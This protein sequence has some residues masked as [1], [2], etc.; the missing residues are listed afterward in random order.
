MTVQGTKYWA[1]SKPRG[2]SY[3][4]HMNTNITRKLAAIVAL[5]SGSSLGIGSIIAD[6]LAP[7]RADVGNVFVTNGGYNGVQQILKLSTPL[8]PNRR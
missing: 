5:L 4:V 6:P 7:D 1:D 8:S 2:K 3:Q